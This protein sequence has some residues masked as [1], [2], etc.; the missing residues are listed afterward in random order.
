MKS[1]YLVLAEG[2]YTA[3]S[4]GGMIRKCGILKGNNLNLLDEAYKLYRAKEVGPESPEA[5]RFKQANCYEISKIKFIGVWDTVGAL[6]IPLAPFQWINKRKYAFYDTTLSSIVENAYHAISV[7]EKRMNFKPALWERSKNDAPR[8]FGQ[9][10]EQLWFAGVHSNVGGGYPDEGLA[11]VALQWMIEKA[12]DSGLSFEEGDVKA[13]LKE[14][15]QG[16]LYE[17]V[18]GIFKFLPKYER[19]ITTGEIHSSVHQRMRQVKTYRP[20]NIST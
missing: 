4:L 5:L 10:L 2:A 7:D 12:M 15:V 13:D 1:I 17:S 14:N 18:K 6:G 8:E 20:P 9:K 19:P 11:D 3:R 16:K